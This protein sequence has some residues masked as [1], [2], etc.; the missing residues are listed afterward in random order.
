MLT[1]GLDIDGVCCDFAETYLRLLRELH[2]VVRRE[3]DITNFDFS[4]CVATPQ[5]DK[6][7]WD[8]IERSPGLVYNLP[9]YDGAKGFLA[10]LRQL[11]RVVACTAPA[12]PRW[13]AERWQWL[14]DKAGFKSN[15]IVLTHSK[16]FCAF[17]FLVDDAEHNL[18]SWGHGSKVL[19]ARPWNRVDSEDSYRAH[20]Y[21]DVLDFIKWVR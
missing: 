2:G 17:D 18:R 3:E 8:Y 19:F 7:I 11:G 10:E 4:K 14:E 13:A 9:L 21:A 16:N 6:A 20:D 1:I 5:Q 15:D 12:S